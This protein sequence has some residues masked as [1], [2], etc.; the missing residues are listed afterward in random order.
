MKRRGYDGVV[1]CA[2][3]S[4]PYRRYSV[5]S[6][7][8]WIGRALHALTQRTGLRP[9]DIDGLSVSSFTLAPDT[10]IGLTQHL[11]LSPRWLDHVPMGGAGG[12][13]SL[14]RAARAVQAGDADFVA[15]IGADTNHVDSFR[16][17][18]SSFSRFAQD[19]V[20][21]YGSGGPNAS[22]ALI[23]RNYMNRTGATR[24]DFGRICVAQ[25]TN[26]QR[27]GGALMQKPLTMDDYLN[28][29]PIAD[30]I[31]LFDCV[32]PCAGAEAFLICRE[33]DAKSLDLPYVRILSAIERHNAYQDDPI[34]FRGGWAMDRD[35]LWAMAGIQPDAVDFLQTYDDY[36]V[37]VMMQIEDLG[38]CAKGEAPAFVRSHTLTTDGDFPHNT[39]GGQL[40]V[41]QAGAAGGHLGLVE[42][43]RQLTDQA[44]NTAVPNANIGLVSGFG[45]INYD[46]GLASSAVLLARA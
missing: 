44:G 8:W 17:T 5:D 23:T 38:F 34:Q 11:G 7:H 1:L 9:T 46:R 24:E 13:V 37:I 6:A 3:I 4:I 36:P 2:P 30:P 33:D 31:H 19:A 25:R 41:G 10:T 26:A 39:S 15:C 43:I 21:P 22:F 16:K 32:M 27:Y 12:C 40:S 28:A 35:D 45:M 20:Y 29:R 42:A 14:R 18:L